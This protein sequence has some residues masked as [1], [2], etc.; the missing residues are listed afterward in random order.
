MA[1]S[2]IFVMAMRL[3]GT[4][5][6]SDMQLVELAWLPGKRTIIQIMLRN[7]PFYAWIF[8]EASRVKAGNDAT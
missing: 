3:N 2:S 4:I 5:P 1:Q 6:I 7:S 8:P